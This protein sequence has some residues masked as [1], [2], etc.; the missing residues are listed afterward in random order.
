MASAARKSR[1]AGPGAPVFQAVRKGRRYQQ[2]AEQIQRLVAEGVLRPGDHLP[3]ERDLALQFGVGRS[4]L[5]DAI[6]TLEVLGVVESRHGAGTVIRDL[7][8]DALVV[9]L[10]RALLR[11]R[12]M[13]AE[14]L[15]VRRMIEPALAGRAAR[16]VTPAEIAQM[17]EILQ[18]QAARIRRGEPTIE[19]DSEFHAA[20][21][22]AARNSV[23]LRILDV[24]MHLLR[25][26]RARSLQF[27]GRVEKSYAGHQRILR[28]L[29]RRD[30][31]A[32]EDAVRKHLEEIEAIVMRKL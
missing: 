11:K 15:E 21:M 3:A 19:E 29:K 12:E 27:P 23:V 4:S 1:L 14:L 26:S 30:S 8:A 5:R 6:R 28:A 18:R 9:P 7:D 13:V 24:L 16:N 32:A 20:L 25:E 10:A 31:G 2:I 17:E 22:R